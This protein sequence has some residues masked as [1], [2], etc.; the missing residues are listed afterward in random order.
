MPPLG[1]A[2][3]SAELC[4]RAPRRGLSH[5]HSE[6]RQDKGLEDLKA[7][8]RTENPTENNSQTRPGTGEAGSDTCRRALEGSNEGGSV[9]SAAADAWR[10]Q[11]SYRNATSSAALQRCAHPKNSLRNARFPHTHAYLGS[12]LPRPV[13]AANSEP[14]LTERAHLSGASPP[15]AVTVPGE[16]AQRA[17]HG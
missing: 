7:K 6:L 3:H 10:Q 8:G 9:P 11:L 15:T 12:A 14:I 2:A 16:S 4:Q 1:A 5:T 13:P 17:A